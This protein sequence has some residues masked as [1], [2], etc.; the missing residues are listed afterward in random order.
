MT[1]RTTSFRVAIVLIERRPL[2]N[3]VVAA[4]QVKIIAV[5]V[6]SGRKLMFYPV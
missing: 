6:W 2:R 4:L 3:A 5:A 1:I